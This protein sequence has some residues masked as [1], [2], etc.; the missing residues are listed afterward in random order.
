MASTTMHVSRDAGFQ[1]DK[2]NVGQLC[3]GNVDDTRILTNTNAHEMID[4][5]TIDQSCL[6]YFVVEPL[7]FEDHLCILIP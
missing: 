5:A 6:H 3:D 2:G 7:S 1:F 4:S